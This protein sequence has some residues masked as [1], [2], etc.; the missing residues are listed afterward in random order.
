[1][2]E[3]IRVDN[4]EPVVLLG[5]ELVYRQEPYWCKGSF[6]SLTISLLRDRC[7]YDYDPPEHKQPVILFL[8]GGS[9]TV[10][11]P[12][13][14]MPEMT[15]FA[16]LG[17]AVASVQYSVI[18]QTDFPNQ[19]MEIRQA[20]RFLR[21]HADELRLDPDRIAVMGES[22]GGHL[23]ML[24]ALSA[25]RTEFDN[26]EYAEYSSAVNC[27]VLYYAP[28]GVFDEHPFPPENGP[29]KFNTYERLLR[30]KEPWNNPEAMRAIDVREYV[31]Q[32]APPFMLLYGTEDVVIPVWHGDAIYDALTGAGIPTEYL[33][34]EGGKHASAEFFQTETKERVRRFLE[35]YL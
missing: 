30:E 11:D 4:K 26:G 35:K 5:T 33:V 34:I 7:R 14:W 10:M 17:Y 22:A 9:F 15:Y 16:K 32:D 27:A 8:C 6:R 13:V 31:H 25:N 1:M 24:T 2:F 18:G 29:R 20:I 3:K 21:A 12:D 28:S 23:A 19:I